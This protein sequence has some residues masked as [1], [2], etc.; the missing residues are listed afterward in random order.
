MSLVWVIES[1]KKNVE[2]CAKYEK[3][4]EKCDDIRK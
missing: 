3:H 1:T 2:P 4:E